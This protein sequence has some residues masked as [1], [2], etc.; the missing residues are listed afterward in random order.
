[1]RRRKKNQRKGEVDWAVYLLLIFS[2]FLLLSAFPFLF[3]FFFFSRFWSFFNIHNFYMVYF[4]IYT[5]FVS[6]GFGFWDIFQFVFITL[7]SFFFSYF[8]HFYLL[9]YSSAYRFR[10]SSVSSVLFGMLK[11]TVCVYSL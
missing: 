9:W 8:V 6:I 2:L 10:T 1:M 5:W 4:H 11:W 3:L 7:T